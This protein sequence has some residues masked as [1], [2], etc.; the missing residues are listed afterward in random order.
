MP[1]QCIAEFRQVGPGCEARGQ[2]AAC[3]WQPVNGNV[4]QALCASRRVLACPPALPGEEKVE[5][6][7]KT[8]GGY[9]E[10]ARAVFLPA[11]LEV[12]PGERPVLLLRG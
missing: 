10:D 3:D 9:R 12:R 1:A 2:I 4:V 11:F 8:G 6:A 5:P 7:A